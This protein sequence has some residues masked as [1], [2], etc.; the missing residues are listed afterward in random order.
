MSPTASKITVESSVHDRY[1]RSAREPETTMTLTRLVK[2]LE[3]P[4]E[5]VRFG[6][7][8]RLKKV[9]S[10]AI[11]GAVRRVAA[12]DPSTM[13]RFE[14]RRFLVAAAERLSAEGA[15][16][17]G[18]WRLGLGDADPSVRSRAARL[19][20]PESTERLEA[21]RELVREG[22]EDLTGALRVAA[23]TEQDSRVLA[24]VISALGRMGASRDARALARFLA[25]A[26]NRIRA[27][28][29]ESIGLLSD[30]ESEDLLTPLLQDPSN[31]V[32]ANATVALHARCESLAIQTLHEMVSSPD[33]AAGI[34]AV[35]AAGTLASPAA[36]RLLV[37]AAHSSAEAVA[38]RARETLSALAPSLR[39]AAQARQEKG[40]DT[41]TSLPG[42]EHRGNGDGTVSSQGDSRHGAGLS[43][44]ARER[45]L[46]D[47]RH[48]SADV[49][50]ETA[51]KVA[52]A[53]DPSLLA[54][55]QRLLNDPD[56]SVRRAARDAI[57]ATLRSAATSLLG[58]PGEL[59][60]FT[61]ELAGE[62]PVARRALS[63]LF[64]I[65]L[66]CGAPHIA[67]ALATRLP[68]ESRIELLPIL[69]LALGLVSDSS[70]VP[71]LRPFLQHSCAQVRAC[72]I[73]AIALPGNA[74]DLQAAVTCLSDPDPQV[75]SA[76]IRASLSIYKEPFLSHL[77][78]LLVSDLEAERS[79][80][81]SI[82]RTIRIPEK[83][84]LLR[85][86]LL[87][88]THPELYA[89]SAD[90]L[91]QE[92]TSGDASALSNLLAELP[93][94]DKQRT[95][96]AAAG[97]LLEPPETP[98]E[99]EPDAVVTGVPAAAA[100]AD[101]SPPALATSLTEMIVLHQLDALTPEAVR[102][103]LMRET[104]PAQLSM[105]LR[106]A[107]EIK[108]PDLVDL[109]SRFTRAEDRRVR[110]AAVE[111]LALET[112]MA[113]QR[114]V[115]EFV[116]DR[117]PEVARTAMELLERRGPEAKME[118]IRSLVGTNQ[119]W[120]MRR[121]LELLEALESATSL[122]LALQILERGGGSPATFRA[123][124]KILLAWGDAET[125]AKLGGLFMRGSPGT[126]PL[127]LELGKLLGRKLGLEAYAVE[128]RFP[129]ELL[130]VDHTGDPRPPS[131]RPA[132]SS[133][134]TGGEPNRGPRSWWPFG[135]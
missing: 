130:P 12:A 10:L 123:L 95:V 76:A 46:L 34:S 63:R 64:E 30:G 49:R 67:R 102:A 68:L 124:Q 28:A 122:P 6:A 120:A 35:W 134:D 88:E 14:A 135:K 79:A 54:A 100:S 21:V 86:H 91:V 96:R 128:A 93:E 9:P 23:Q 69:L 107:V 94:G 129:Q 117:D 51:R 3:S 25:S 36:V 18:A 58:D 38:R 133:P 26:D 65:S 116:R 110:L 56:L 27:N 90:L 19:A 127:L 29:V 78:G 8:E 84:A 109:A 85:A 70:A 43:D 11:L 121:A 113:A 47:L 2:D 41:D 126:R 89:A 62:V 44:A 74:E 42:Q 106:V 31:R 132:G 24:T 39:E 48:E 57:K 97:A 59:E 103:S 53:C 115:A 4:L 55:L 71:A 60:N 61:A 119:P 52:E 92:C 1:S 118:G 87:V 108:L 105:M 33:P 73:D 81:I 104:D 82:L 17:G 111:T 50:L 77:R 75:R 32:R 13:L 22:R 37:T 40:K 83:P 112:G 125:L 131:R 20:S 15:S 7:F 80:G 114:K 66:R 99:L 72:A 101:E 98:I 45:L 16:A 5:E